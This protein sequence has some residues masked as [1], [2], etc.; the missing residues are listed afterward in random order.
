MRWAINN[1]KTDNMTILIYEHDKRVFKNLLSFPQRRK[2]KNVSNI[3]K[4]ICM[5]RKRTFKKKLRTN[6]IK[7]IKIKKK[8]L[9]RWWPL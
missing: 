2:I 5:K 9:P 7:K 3:V 8:K 6:V 4:P 1:V